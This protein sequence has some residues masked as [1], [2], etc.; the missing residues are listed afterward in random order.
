MRNRPAISVVIVSDYAAGGPESW[1]RIR[2]TLTALARQD[3]D[4]PTEFLL[5]ESERF[6]DQLP[7]ELSTILPSLRTLFFPDIGSYALKNRGVDAAAAEYVALVDADCLPGSTWLRRMLHALRGNPKLAA[8]SGRTVYPS[9]SFT[10][11]VSALLS[12]SYL[13]P[14]DAAETHYIATNNC[15]VR[16]AAYLAHPLPTEIGTFSAHVQ[17]HALARD[18]WTLWFEPEAEVTHD[19]EG[20]AMEADLR[21]NAGHGTIAAG[22]ASSVSYAWLARMGPVAI[23]PLLAGKILGSWRDC[24]RCGGSYHIPWYGVPAAMLLSIGVHALEAPGML[25]AYKRAGLKSSLFR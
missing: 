25:R 24:I 3:L 1:E 17:S 9:A 10:G 18:G 8:V 23:V 19:F 11:R 7:P 6:R 2:R 22:L 15:A 12:R 5:I 14:G 13:D 21:R 20:W 4:E 16:R